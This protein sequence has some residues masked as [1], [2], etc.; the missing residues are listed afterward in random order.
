MNDHETCHH[1]PPPC[2]CQHSKQSSS[3]SSLYCQ[4]LQCYNNHTLKPII[5]HSAVNSSQFFL[6]L[7]VNITLACAHHPT[8]NTSYYSL[9]A[10]SEPILRIHSFFLTGVIVSHLVRKRGRIMDMAFLGNCCFRALLLQYHHH[11]KM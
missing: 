8:M 3:S 6:Q 7:N 10:H 1:Q 5:T 4:Q 11:H 2:Y 9:H